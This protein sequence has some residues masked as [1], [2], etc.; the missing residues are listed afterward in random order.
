LNNPLAIHLAKMTFA[1]TTKRSIEHLMDKI[2]AI[3]E[4]KKGIIKK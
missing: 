1:T 3:K 2:R 4:P